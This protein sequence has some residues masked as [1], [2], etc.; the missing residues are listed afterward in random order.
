MIIF[1]AY[2]NRHIPWRC[3]VLLPVILAFLVLIDV[4]PAEGQRST[5]TYFANTEFELN[6]YRINGER[7]GPTMMIIGGIQD[8]PGGYL[9][10]DQ[11]VDVSLTEGNLILAPRSNFGTIIAGERGVYGD[12]NRMFDLTEQRFP[13]DYSIDVVKVLKD[14]IAESDILINL[15]DG[16]GFYRTEYIDDMHQ[17]LRYGQSI[18]SD[19]DVYT[20][21]L[22]GEERTLRLQDTAE[23]VCARVNEQIE[24]S[25]HAFRYNNHDT[26][27]PSTMHAEQRKSA[28][29]YSLT[30][31]HIPAFAVE[32]SKNIADHALK[33]RYQTLAIFAFMDYFGI[34]RDVLGKPLPDPQF[35]F[36]AISVNG[37]QPRLYSSGTELSVS[38]GDSI[39][40]DHVEANYDRGLSAE[41]LGHGGSN[42]LGRFV[43]VYS[44]TSI[45]FRKDN[46]RFGEIDIR[47]DG[48]A[49]GANGDNGSHEPYAAFRSFI[50]DVNGYSRTVGPNGILHV[51]RGDIV[52][53][54]GTD[55]PLH[56]IPGAAVNIRGFVPPDAVRNTGDDTGYPVDTARDLLP[57]YSRYEEGS[58][59][60]VLFSRGGETVSEMRFKIV[61][62]ELQY[63]ILQLENGNKAYLENGDTFIAGGS[64]M[65]SVRNVK[66]NVPN[67]EGVAVNVAGLAGNGAASD[68]GIPFSVAGDLLPRYSIDGDGRRYGIDVTCRERVIGRVFI[69]I[70]AP[71]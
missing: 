54:T 65:L 7:P 64:E 20:Y 14:C 11:F 40:I 56:A 15:H 18:I 69:R 21:T 52:T 33:V 23:W 53:I 30:H 51:L 12:M 6:I 35:E 19:T 8:E 4:A 60:R 42:D 1:P 39:R 58:E 68:T 27:S 36:A 31:H 2:I 5:E 22:D 71:R 47:V 38:A 55:P 63:V 46:V 57:A 32:T 70:R 66:T 24:D 37:E 28:T 67:N 49:D 26:F 3:C 41:I 59:Y 16:S 17:P 9:T 10:A 25:Y 61:D 45:V 34:K 44:P 62:P 29:F 48:K 13:G 50:V 43:A